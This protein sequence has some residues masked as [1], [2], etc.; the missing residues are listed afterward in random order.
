MKA[1]PDNIIKIILN[2]KKYRHQYEANFDDG[3]PL[4]TVGDQVYMCYLK[5]KKMNFVAARDFLIICSIH[6]MAESGI[7][8]CLFYSI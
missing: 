1:S 3:G 6:K 8:Y 2:E 7:I 4:I 5:F